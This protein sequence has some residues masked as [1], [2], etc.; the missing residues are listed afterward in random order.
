MF[1][2]CPMFNIFFKPMFN[3]FFTNICLTYCE[4]FVCSTYV[5]HTCIIFLE[6]YDEHMLQ[7]VC[8]VVICIL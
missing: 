6:K 3:L 1:L 7:Y 4:K 2:V 8:R 5:Q